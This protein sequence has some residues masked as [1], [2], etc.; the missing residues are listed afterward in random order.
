M[1]QL[2]T[3]QLT[4]VLLIIVSIMA[5]LALVGVG[6]IMRNIKDKPDLT[7]DYDGADRAGLT[8]NDEEQG[9]E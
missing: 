9:N 3:E 4:I 2:M 6:I 5:V 8:D 7:I 1:A